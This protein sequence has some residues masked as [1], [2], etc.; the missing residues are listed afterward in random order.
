MQKPHIHAGPTQFS[1]YGSEWYDIKF[2]KEYHN[3]PDGNGCIEKIEQKA[4]AN[5]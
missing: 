3:C 5:P 4:K 1:H 2:V